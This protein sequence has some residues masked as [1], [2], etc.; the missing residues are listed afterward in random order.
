MENIEKVYLENKEFI[1]NYLYGL[2]NNKEIAEDLMSEVFLKSIVGYNSF[3]NKSSERTWLYSIARYTF[4]EYIRGKNKDKDLNVLFKENF[5]NILNLDNMED[6][7]IEKENIELIKKY[8]DNF[9]E[10]E[11]D[12]FIYRV[13]GYSYIEISS[14]LKISEGSSRVIFFRTREKLKQ[15]ILKGGFYD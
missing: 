5:I 13:K 8:L 9:N 7:I 4:Y 1:F 12:V 2:T 6:I 10:R 3:K 15:M 11:K 14:I